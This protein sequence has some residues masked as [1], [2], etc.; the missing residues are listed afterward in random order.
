MAISSI[1]DTSNKV[2]GPYIK[3][4]LGVGRRSPGAAPI[5]VL[6][7][8]NKTSAGSAAVNTRTL[9]ASKDDA[10]TQFGAGSELFMLCQAA[11]KVFPTVTLYG[12]VVTES[13]G[14]LGTR[15]L[16]FGGGPAT[17][18][19]TVEVWVG[20]RRTVAAIAVGDTA[21]VVGASVAAAINAM[22]D[23]PVTAANAA[24]TVTVSSKNKGPRANFIKVRSLMTGGA[25]IT[26]TPVN[27]YLINGATSDDPQGALDAIAG[28]RFHYIVAPYSD[29]TNLVKFETHI[30]GQA[31]PETGV[32]ERCIFASLDTLANT[33]TLSDAINAKRGQ[34]DWHYNSEQTP[35]E[36]A[37]ADA[38]LLA[39]ELASDRAK[40]T[41]GKILDGIDPQYA[42]ADKPLNSEL[43]TA[44]NNGI[45]PIDHDGSR[46]F[47][48][49]HITNYSTDANAQ[50]DFSVLDVQNVEVADF[51][52]DDIELNFSSEFAEYKLDNDPPQGE[53]PEPKTATPSSIKAWIY[54]RLATYA[55]GGSGPL[56]LSR[57][58]EL[59]DEIVVEIDSIADGR[60]NAVIPI[61][62]VARFHQ[63]AAEV[64]HV[65]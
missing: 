33:V 2:P 24:G 50:P 13:A 40:N 62:V 55:A 21:T 61:D 53:T 51:I 42:L 9:I 5:K 35:G 1:I 14:A 52:A 31:Q 41:D 20:G 45:T 12:L 60:A 48:V 16:V 10:R 34:L 44:L 54:S 58:P 46:C 32:R 63:F 17:S 43:V 27:A 7:V 6:V 19:G 59:K 28:E 23:W 18:A 22:T 36:I 49:R 56:L 29:S 26:H 65:G 38:A 15:D 11:L 39:K 47:I 57:V 30:D 8:G 3:V 25:A 64:R 37:A 4:T